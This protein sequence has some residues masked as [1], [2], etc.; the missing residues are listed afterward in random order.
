M[1]VKRM[2]DDR[3]FLGLST[4]TKPDNLIGVGGQFT[5]IDTGAKAFWDGARWVEDL[6]LI[7]A[8]SEALKLHARS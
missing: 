3:K 5:E 1:A 7:Y 4:D 8:F 2:L 6:T